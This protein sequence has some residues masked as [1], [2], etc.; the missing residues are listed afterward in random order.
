MEDK[1]IYT[2]CFSGHRPNNLPW[3]YNEQGIKFLFFKF[4][5]K[6]KIKSAI[7][8]GYKYFISG[9]ALGCDILCAEIIIQF[10]K[11]NPNIKLECA[12]PCSNQ[13]E[14]WFGNNLK[15][16]EKILSKAD[17]IT[18]VSLSKYFNGC[19]MK[20]NNY[21]INSSSSIIA[22]YNGT[23]GGTQQTIKKAKEKGLKITI[24]KP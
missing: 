8:N 19:M 24:I 11:Q 7:N 9:M 6:H 14:K 3:K 10:K 17:K 18:Y 16:Y 22:I 5:L 15:R 2:C 4:K 13:T 23:P 12:I 1:R 21:M 20:R